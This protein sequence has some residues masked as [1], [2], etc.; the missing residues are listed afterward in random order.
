MVHSACAVYMALPSAVKHNI[1]RSGLATAAP[2]ASGKAIPIEPPVLASQSCGGDPLVAA[3]RPR[4]EVMDSSTTIAFLGSSAP[5]A[6]AIPDRVTSPP[7]TGGGSCLRVC[8]CVPPSD[9][10]DAS[11]SSAPAQSSPG[12][13]SAWISH[14]AYVSTAFFPGAAKYAT[15][16]FAPTKIS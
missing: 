15:G 16:A 11:A 4:P 9:K 12:L 6:F 2:T 8:G 3:I 1:G 13:A 5:T 10:A 14:S 7:G